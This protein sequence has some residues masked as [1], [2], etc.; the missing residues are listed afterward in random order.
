[1]CL[2]KIFISHKDSLQSWEELKELYK[3][4]RLGSKFYVVCGKQRVGKSSLCNSMVINNER[5]KKRS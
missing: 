2:K 3:P 4:E 5:F 1:M